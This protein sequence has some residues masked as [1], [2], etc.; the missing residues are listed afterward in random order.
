M[1]SRG[2]GDR[3]GRGTTAMHVARVMLWSEV[4]GRGRF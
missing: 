4:K 3:V 2:L 1:G